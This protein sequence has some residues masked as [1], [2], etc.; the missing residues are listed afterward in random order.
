MH[1][2][3]R[4]ARLLHVCS[5]VNTF[6][7]VKAARSFLQDRSGNLAILFVFMSTA[8]FL[9]VGGAVDYTR[10]NA[11]RADMIE[12]MDAASLAVAKL[13]E[14]DESLSTAQLKE[15]GEKFFKENFEYENKLKPGWNIEF[16]VDDEAVIDTCITGDLDTL[17][18]RVA[19]IYELNID[20]CVQVTP[21]GAGRI[22]LAMVLDVTGSMGSND[23]NGA[24]KM[25]SLRN[26]V[27]TL[28]DVLFE[29]E[30]TSDRVR[31]GVVPF[32]THVNVG[33]STGWSASWG[34]LEAEAVYHGARFFHVDQNGVVDASKKVNHY[35][36]FNS[37]PRH[38]WEGCVEARPYP[39]DELDTEP[40]AN[41]TAAY[42]S[43][44]MQSLTES[45][46]PDQ[47]MR[48]AFNNMPAIN[49]DLTL[50][51]IADVDN[52]RWVPAFLAD[53]PDC[54]SDRECYSEDDDDPYLETG[55]INGI[56]WDSRWFTDPDD[57]P[58][59]TR[60]RER[61]YINRSFVGDR[62]ITDYTIGTG[63]EKYVPIVYHFREVINGNVSDPDFSDWLDKMRV[64]REEQEYIVRTGYPGWYNPAQD[65]YDF[66]YQYAENHPNQ[67]N[68]DDCP[69][70]VLPLTNVRADVDGDDG[71][72][73]DLT[74][75]GYTNIP[76]GAVWGWRLVSPEPPFTEAIG[77]G[78][79]GPGG[80]DHED[81]QKAVLIMTDG[82]NNFDDRRT[83]WGSR[84][85]AYGY[86][87]E[88]RMGD[89]IDEADTGT[90]NMEDEAD[91]KLLRICRRMKQENILVYSVVFDVSAGSNI[92]DV[93]KSCATRPTAPYFFNAPNGD[94]LNEAF[95]N[96]A[97]DLVKLH[98]SR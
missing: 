87:F 56:N 68:P 84:P 2:L 76:F 80:T 20:K 97:D 3:Q 47:K 83:H 4:S 89:G 77:P 93:F 96:I 14:A 61:S 94:E 21:Q 63:F 32:N 50:A 70:A 27:T 31:I 65:K 66:R 48:S 40:G 23:S 55:T 41:T 88:E 39:L 7:R 79:T 44:E 36:L 26:A 85:S 54:N 58:V 35:E 45:Q 53:D 37:D 98:V 42:L 38:N 11:V 72:M 62:R 1:K 92:E 52:S 18:L 16:D 12:S 28:L 81:W 22:E 51:Q 46:E 24:Y 74:P 90:P 17:L 8:L 49:S 33:A 71:I 13:A 60:V 69:A 67:S 5:D 57:D 34:D 82:N 29:E 19:G 95:S 86:Q 6:L 10:W 91:N 73:D 43:G 9:F 75:D 78:E 59:H 64:T 30:E 25:T 15:Y